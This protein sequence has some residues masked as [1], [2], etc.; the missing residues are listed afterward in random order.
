MDKILFIFLTLF[1][2]SGCGESSSSPSTSTSK[3]DNNTTTQESNT[4]TPEANT[5]TT[6]SLAL[7]NYYA[8]ALDKNGTA[9]KSALHL[10][11]AD[12]K[13]FTYSQV[14]DLLGEIDQD[15]RSRDADKVVLFYSQT[16]MLVD[17]KCH[18]TSPSGC[19]N[20]EHLW[21]KSLGVGYDDTVA[22]YTDMHHLRPVKA[23]VNTDRSNR[24][25]G[26]A[27]TP[28]PE[29]EGFYYDDTNWIWEVSDN[30]KGDVARVLFYMS[31]RYEGENNEPNLELYPNDFSSSRPAEL[32]MMLEWNK[33]DPVSDTEVRRNDAIYQY[34]QNRNPFVD[35]PDWA[36]NIW[37]SQC[38]SQ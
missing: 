25:F 26:H 38:S 34:Q 2:L 21:P 7:Q 33:F 4:S 3:Q 23:V 19:W 1:L 16:S 28:Y 9:L 24:R 6:L 35:K 29:I 5:T 13:Y 10:I 27:T 14:Y 18:T 12:A 17:D 32:C 31:V 22:S 11:I 20:R 36:D 8:D 30:L 37:A 15:L